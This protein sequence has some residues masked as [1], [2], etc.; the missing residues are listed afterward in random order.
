MVAALAADGFAVLPASAESLA[1]AQAAAQVG[2]AVAADPDQQA[3]WLQCEGTWFV[4]VDALPNA[5]DGSVD[6]AGLPT[7]LKSATEAA[8]GPLG[9]LH[10]AQL[11]VVY[12]GYPRPRKGESDGAFRYRLNRD[13][14]HVDGLLAEGPERRRFLKEPHQFIL[15]ISL[16][17]ADAGAAPLVV[18]RGSHRII[19]RA[20][21]AM[22]DDVPEDRRGA[23]DV[24]D[25]YTAARREV[26][27][28]CKRVPVP[29]R[30]GEAVLLHPHLLHGIAPWAEG[31][32]AAP[33]GR[34]TA[35]FRPHHPQGIMGWLN[36]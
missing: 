28:T 29:L 9:P 30:P 3:A 36:A 18:W 23:V 27:E 14:A 34:M 26:F 25:G 11:S 12:P 2:K 21:A 20:F 6:G 31:A 1:W 4:G 8:F 16:T 33:E 5:P 15:G 35:Y 24:T 13:A 10:P 32:R 22:L 7:V 19:G 17:E